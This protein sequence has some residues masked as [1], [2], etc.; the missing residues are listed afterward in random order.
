MSFRGRIPRN[1]D[2][3]GR[4]MLPPEYR[5]A[6][7][8]LAKSEDGKLALTT[9]DDCVVGIP[10]PLWLE[11]EN[12]LQA[13]KNPSEKLRKFKRLVM[14]GATV[15]AP[16]SQGRI[17][18]NQDQLGYAGIAD[19][20]YLVGNSERFELWLPQRFEENVLRQDYSDISSELPEGVGLIF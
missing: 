5:E 15:G 19:E 9:Y 20:A 3:Q 12:K 4:I 10:L 8:H 1:V 16:D 2:N 14:S 18:L 6:L 13:I 17:R 11:F 7:T